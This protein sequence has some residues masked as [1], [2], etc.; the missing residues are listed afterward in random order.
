[1][2]ISSFPESKSIERPEQTYYNPS[3][4]ASTAWH[5]PSERTRQG[6]AAVKKRGPKGQDRNAVSFGEDSW[7]RGIHV[8]LLQQVSAVSIFTEIYI[9]L[10][11]SCHEITWNPDDWFW[12]FSAQRDFSQVNYLKR[13]GNDAARTVVTSRQCIEQYPLC[14]LIHTGTTFEWGTDGIYLEIIND[15]KLYEWAIS[16][17]VGIAFRLSCGIL[18][19]AINDTQGKSQG[20]NSCDRPSNLTQIGF[21]SSI[22]F[23]LC[24][25]EI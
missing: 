18:Y 7:V 12:H 8:C 20:F 4:T 21:K 13:N 19:Y 5:W 22:F 1:M 9:L 14:M 16:R 6:Q 2:Y 23:S 15:I 11:A 10:V 17:A 3:T 24:D 25:L